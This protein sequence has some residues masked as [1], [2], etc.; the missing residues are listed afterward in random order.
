MKTETD[1]SEGGG[2][3]FV[4]IVGRIVSNQTSFMMLLLFVMW[5]VFSQ[6]SPHFFT[7][8]NL[9]E[10]TIEASVICMVAAGQTI[11][12]L[13]SGIDLGAGSVVALTAVVS[14]M[15]MERTGTLIPGYF[16]GLAIGA[17]CGLFNGLVIG[18]MNVPPFVSTLGL[19]GIARGIALIITN[20]VPQYQLATGSDFLG[21]GKVI[22]LPVPTIAVFLLYILCYLILSRTRRGRYTYAIGSNSQASFLSGIKVSNQLIWV[23]VV[24]GLTAG[25]AGITELS[26]I[27]SGQPAA[28]GDY[29]LD[30]IAAVCVGGTS[31]QG[32]IGN[33]WGTLIGG[34]IIASMRNGLNVTNINAF[35]QQVVIG[36]I[37][38]AAVYA[39]QLRHHMRR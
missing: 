2:S 23:Y 15:V 34:L 4:S 11:V 21:Q 27:G 35:W 32:G 17:V 38:I 14:A 20:G 24:A 8:Q 5:G 9:A 16:A 26:R 7:S 10:I 29:A 28:G 30:S 33:I 36:L 3:V 19:M 12:I 39:D 37:L 22:G 18:K 31:L 25:I 6:L 13:S 1:N